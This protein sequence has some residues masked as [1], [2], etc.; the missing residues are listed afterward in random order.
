MRQGFS[1]CGLRIDSEGLR[2]T[3]A[4]RVTLFSDRRLT[5]PDLEAVKRELTWRFDLDAGLSDFDAAGSGDRQ[6]RPVFRKWRGSRDSWHGTLYELLVISI[7]LQ[8]ATVRR[9][10][11]MIHALLEKFG[12]RLSFDSKSLLRDVVARRSEQGFG[13]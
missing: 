7:L 6:F 8:N 11:Q 2:N 9:T 13:G 12:T 1:F 5:R 10:V 3:P 4:V